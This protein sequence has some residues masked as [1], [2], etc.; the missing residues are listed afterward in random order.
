[1]TDD[2]M[3]K[4]KNEQKEIEWNP[5]VSSMMTPMAVKRPILSPRP[6]RIKDLSLAA[7]CQGKTH[8]LSDRD[9]VFYGNKT[10]LLLA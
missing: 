1:M 6:I 8:L 2:W 4:V 7:T 10:A 3:V 9:K 5:A